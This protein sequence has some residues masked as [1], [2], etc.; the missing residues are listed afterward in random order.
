MLSRFNFSTTITKANAFSSKSFQ[1]VDISQTELSLL[2]P[3]TDEMMPTRGNRIVMTNIGM[4][5]IL[6]STDSFAT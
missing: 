1:S 3:W 5:F 6:D 4:P 2:I